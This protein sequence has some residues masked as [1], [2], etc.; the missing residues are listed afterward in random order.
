MNRIDKKLA[1]LKDQNKKALVA[2]LVAGDPDL[3]TTHELMHSFVKSGVNIIELGIPFTDPIAEGPIIQKAHDRALANNTS[4]TDALKIVKRFRETDTET[5]VI[6]MGYLNTFVYFIKEVNE[7][8]E[9]GVDGVLVVDIPGELKLEN[10]GLTN[11]DIKTISLISP[12]TS[13][14]RIK[15]ICSNSSGFIYYVTLKGV[16]GSA[17]LDTSDVNTNIKKIKEHTDLPILAGFGIKTVEDVKN[18][19]SVSDGVVIGS[20]IVQMINDASDSKEF[21]RIETYL[22]KIRD[23]LV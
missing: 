9:I 14:D 22:N 11:K 2:Y 5:P 20:S 13:Q 1:Q 12:T 17:E 16:T 6:L 21:A 18:L 10:Y 23:A 8:N 15:S 4:F 7:S 19:A 3:D